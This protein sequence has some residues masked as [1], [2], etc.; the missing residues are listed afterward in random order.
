MKRYKLKRIINN[1]KGGIAIFMVPIII[2]FLIAAMGALEY[3]TIVSAYNDIQS[4]MDLVANSALRRG[5]KHD[6]HKDEQIIDSSGTGIIDSSNDSIDTKTIRKVYKQLLKTNLDKSIA[7]HSL[8]NNNS[9]RIMKKSGNTF[10][11]DNSFINSPESA[12]SP[13][14][15]LEKTT[16]SNTFTNQNKLVDTV[17]LDAVAEVDLKASKFIGNRVLKYAIKQKAH[18]GNT[19]FEIEIRNQNSNATTLL[20]RSSTRMILK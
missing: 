14:I 8:L 16:W 5:V 17:I 2:A 13:E 3:F 12:S 7:R 6:I 11:V 15:R 19:N 18:T 4:I 20:I 10:I 9:F 1:K